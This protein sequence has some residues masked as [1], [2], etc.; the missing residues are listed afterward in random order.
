M[1][2][3]FSEAPEV[4]ELAREIIRK[5]H[6]HLDAEDIRIVYLFVDPPPES[7]GKL[8]FGRC[9]KVT[10]LNAFL[11]R[12]NAPRDE[13]EEPDFGDPFFVIEIAERVWQV[14]EPHQRRALVDH[15]LC[16]AAV[17]RDEEDVPKLSI[18]P[19]DVE[20][21]TDI[22]NRHGLWEEGLQ[23]FVAEALATQQGE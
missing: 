13:D 16:H 9:R 17:I 5:D 1:A 15:E 4:A 3:V 20:E 6:P 8:V 12:E 11:A 19:H 22:V 10:G 14:L 21:F 2:S 23:D 7:K 18:R